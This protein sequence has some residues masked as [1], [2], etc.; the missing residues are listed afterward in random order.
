MSNSAIDFTPIIILKTNCKHF[1][2]LFINEFRTIGNEK[3]KRIT[4]EK[5]VQKGKYY[6]SWI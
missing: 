6:S 5:N 1:W 4:R 2:F 3:G